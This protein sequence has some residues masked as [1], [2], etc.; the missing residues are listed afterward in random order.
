LWWVLSCCLAALLRPEVAPAQES[1]EA[2]NR[3]GFALSVAQQ[4]ANDRVEA[5]LVA[6]AEATE[7]AECAS[8][9]NA[10][11]SWA[12]PRAQ[13]KSGVS[14]RTGGYSTQPIYDEGRLRRWRARQ[15]L[16]LAGADVEAVTAVVSDLQA[17]M[18]LESF[19]F[20]VSDERRR[21]T[22]DGLIERAL[23]GFRERAELIRRSLDARAWR[24]DDVS[25]ETGG[26][27]F[28]PR[29]QQTRMLEA[30]AVEAGTSRVEVQIRATIVLE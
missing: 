3:V 11:M 6:S 16:V 19:D 22:E 12:L 10:A 25:I 24:L 29:M 1:H 13:G 18:A 17:R 23:E 4:V 7:A 27:G 2:R 30:V 20:S 26:G 9:V 8:Q 28:V 5:V 15:E 14:V 21:R